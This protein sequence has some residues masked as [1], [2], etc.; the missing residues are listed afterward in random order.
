MILLKKKMNPSVTLLAAGNEAYLLGIPARY[1]D[2]DSN[3]KNTLGDRCR[4]AK[5]VSRESQQGSFAGWILG[6]NEDSMVFLG[7]AGSTA[8]EHAI[9]YS[10]DDIPIQ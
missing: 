5:N 3:R 8:P 2:H 4:R 10:W 6:T 1:Q 7:V 9:N